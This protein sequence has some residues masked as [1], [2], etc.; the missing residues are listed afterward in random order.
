MKYRIVFAILA[1]MCM[2]SLSSEGQN[3]AATE[4]Q[5][6]NFMVY[7]RLLRMDVRGQK[8]AIVTDLMGFTP[9]EAAVFWPIYTAYDR[10]LSVVADQRVALIED[11]ANR[12]ASMTDEV[13]MDLAQ[14]SLDLEASRTEVK[15]RH[16]ERFADALS[17]RVAARF[18]QIEN[19]LLNVIDLQIASRLPV[20]Q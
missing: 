1:A 14:R 16:F 20:L 8:M 2:I 19:Q 18:L 17:P 10:E 6:S 3:V 15:R 4:D 9:G 7:Q 13:A 5:E 11:F 12:Y